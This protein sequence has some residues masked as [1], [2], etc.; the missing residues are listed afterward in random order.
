[1]KSYLLSGLVVKYRGADFSSFAKT[2]GHAWLVWEPGDW[3]P[4]QSGSPTLCAP[5]APKGPKASGDALVMAMVPKTDQAVLTLGRDEKCDLAI[6]DATVSLMHLVFMLT[7]KTSW[8]VRDTGSKNGSW[9]GDRKLEA[10]A[11]LSLS[12]GQQVKAGSVQLTFHT[13]QG[14]F[15]RVQAISKGS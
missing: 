12:D 10:G 14:L 3:H 6:N 7:Q 15:W 5:T 8:T 13:P 4:S 11:P 2:N 9:V 1:M